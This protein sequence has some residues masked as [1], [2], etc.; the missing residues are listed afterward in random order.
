MRRYRGFI[1]AAAA[2]LFATMTYWEYYFA[3]SVAEPATSAP[4]LRVRKELKASVAVTPF[5]TPPFR[6]ADSGSF[7]YRPPSG[8]T[9]IEKDSEDDVEPET[10][11][12]AAAQPELPLVPPTAAPLVASSAPVSIT[13]DHL[14][15]F[16]EFCSVAPNQVPPNRPASK[17]MEVSSV[18]LRETAVK[19]IVEGDAE[20][21]K[22]LDRF[23]EDLS[24]QAKCYWANYS[25]PS[26]PEQKLPMCTHNPATDIVIS[27]F[28]HSSGVWHPP[29]MYY[30]FVERLQDGRCPPDR[31]VV[32]DLG[33]NIGS[34]SMYALE[35]GCHV[36]AF[37]ALLINVRRVV[38]TM[39]AAKG[40]DGRPFI[41]RFHGF[42]NGVG[43]TIG[44][45]VVH[46]APSNVG[47]SR[48]GGALEDGRQMQ[49]TSVT[50]FVD[51][52]HLEDLLY[53]MPEGERPQIRV[54]HKD[55][56]GNWVYAMEPLQP[57]HIYIVKV[58]VEGYD[59]AALHSLR[60]LF[61]GGVNERPVAFTSEFY[62]QAV[63]Y[64]SKCDVERVIQYFY[65]L[66]Y[67]YDGYPDAHSF[68]EA[69]QKSLTGETSDVFEGWWDWTP[70]SV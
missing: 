13:N 25:I 5:K 12:E 67:K 56:N 61:E 3:S 28:I 39:I 7:E 36:I 9:N 70:P 60:R 33:L 46:I 51:T 59:A 15:Q 14:H 27:S 24:S 34:W 31:P 21:R 63:L 49:P 68:W 38:Q 8:S 2:L 45:V 50:E 32:L 53:N 69:A 1:L 29:R 40:S 42:R 26:S 43:N 47:A 16:A 37:D 22:L 11:S 48:L 54:G 41:E 65:S 66:G 52:V 20:A 35:R 23:I 10:V 62:P 30:D 57:K 58:D 55:S 18:E 4:T 6:Q 64:Y 19:A 17:F 44:K